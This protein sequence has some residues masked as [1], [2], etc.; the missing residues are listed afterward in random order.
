MKAFGIDMKRMDWYEPQIGFKGDIIG[1]RD[2]QG[3]WIKPEV[4]M[5]ELAVDEIE[6]EI[7]TL[8]YMI[9]RASPTDAAY[10]QASLVNSLLQRK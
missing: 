10:L 5:A 9:S 7:N 6:D 8:R 3:R 1:Y 2:V 4:L